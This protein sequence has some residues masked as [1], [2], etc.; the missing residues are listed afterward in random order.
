MQT[1]IP[2]PK[3]FSQLQ[4]VLGLSLAQ[5]VVIEIAFQHSENPELQS[6]ALEDL[7][8]QIP[9]LVKHYV[10][11]D[12]KNRSEELNGFTVETLH[13]ILFFILHEAQQIEIASETKEKFFKA[14]RKDFPRDRVPVVLLPYLY[15]GDEE[16]PQYQ[17][18]T[19][20][21]TQMVGSLFCKFPT[22]ATL[23]K[24]IL[25]ILFLTGWKRTS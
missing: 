18:Q 6:L 12:R 4:K 13:F 14:L 25:W 1:L 17:L 20:S 5:L 9:E 22:I 15:P 3:L 23:R 19:M 21:S 8:K 11:S 24:I 16:T 7:Q 10:Y 2:S